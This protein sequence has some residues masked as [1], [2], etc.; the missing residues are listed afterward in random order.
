M[1]QDPGDLRQFE[2]RPEE[3]ATS[4]RNPGA[5]MVKLPAIFLIVTAILNGLTACGLAFIGFTVISMPLEQFKK[6]QEMFAF[7]KKNMQQLEKQGTSV[8]DLQQQA[9]M[10]YIIGGGVG[11]AFAALIL[12]GAIQMLR[13]RWYGLAVTTNVVA[14]IP[15]ISCCCILG[16]PF[17]I[18][19]L[20]LLVKPEVKAAFH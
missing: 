15:G 1:S 16:L 19:G 10:M 4:A 3:P 17:G 7:Q 20:V 9:G 18:W 11:L 8:K 2:E 12:L 6:Q 13:L 14:M 5:D